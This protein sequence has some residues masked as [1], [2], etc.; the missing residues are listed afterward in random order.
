[1]V[2]LRVAD[3][4]LRSDVHPSFGES[5][6]TSRS[7]SMVS[8]MPTITPLFDAMFGATRFTLDIRSSCVCNARRSVPRDKA[9]DGF[10]VVVQDFRLGVEHDLQAS[11]CPWKSGIRTSIWHSGAARDPRM[12]SAKIV[13]AHVVIVAVH[14]GHDG[15]FQTQVATASATRR[16][17]SQSMARA[18]LW[19]PRRS[20]NAEC[21]CRP[22]A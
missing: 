8:P 9:W 7:S 6:N 22:A 1:M 3:I 13:A 12:V 14:A 20:R 17:S 19:A 11:S 15:V 21:R 2:F 5:R 18:C 16:G 10:S 4:G